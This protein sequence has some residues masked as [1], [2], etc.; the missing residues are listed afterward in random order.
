MSEAERFSALLTRLRNGD[1]SA[2]RELVT[3]YEPL[4][5]REVRLRLRDRRVGRVFDSMDVAQSVF[6]TFFVRAAAGEY[7]LGGPEDLVRLLVSVAR[8]KLASAA[9]K[10]YAEKRDVRRRA[11][12]DSGICDRVPQSDPSPSRHVVAAD[13]LNHVLAGLSAEERELVAL[14]GD[15]L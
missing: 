11:A 10:E 6:A 12:P 7:E 4:V 15:G 8:N 1:E 9:R 13:L 5:R 14:R 3:R 2:A